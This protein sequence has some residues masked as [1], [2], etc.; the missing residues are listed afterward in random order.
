MLGWPDTVATANATLGL[1][2]AARALGLSGGEVLFPAFGFPAT[3]QALLW[4][5]CV[6]VAVDIEPGRLTIDPAAAA[7]AVTPK[8][9]GIVG[10]HTFGR[11]AGVTGL[12]R[13]SAGSGLA[14]LFDAAPAVGVA[15]NGRPLADHGD[16]SVFSFH[17]TKVLTTLEGGAVVSADPHVT[18]EVRRM[19]AFGLGRDGVGPFGTN[20]K[21]NEV[22]A[23]VGLLGLRR[24]RTDVVRR[25]LL[26]GR[27][28]DNLRGSETVR[29]L[30]DVPGCVTNHAYMPVRVR[31][32]RSPLAD[33]AHAALAQAGVASRRYFGPAYDVAS[34]ALGHVPVSRAAQED[35]LCLPL[36][37]SLSVADVDRTCRVLL[38]AMR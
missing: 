18:E 13:L 26:V 27:Y 38:R 22:Q 34:V 1:Q 31:R 4:A 28:R 3:A 8:T 32:G 10:T 29:W 11:P 33:L 19:R 16:A 6:P 35:V 37:G 14:L 25:G 24:F 5:G 21:L 36:F 23:A 15:L 30:P 7:N 2:L 12:E 17:A 9:L 20:A